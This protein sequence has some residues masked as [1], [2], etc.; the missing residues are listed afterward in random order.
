MTKTLF[1]VGATGYTGQGVVDA[2]VAAGHRVVAHVRP[3]SSAGEKLRG[4]WE[5]DGVVVVECP[6]ELEA[7]TAAMKRHAP[8]AVFS[9]LGTTRRRAAGEGMGAQEAYEKV[10]HDLSVMALE[11]AAELEPRPRFV[12]LSALGADPESTSAYVRARGKVEVRIRESTVPYTIARPS[13]ITGS[14][15]DESRPME[16]AGAVV[17]DGLLGIVGAFG[18]STVRDRYASMTGDELG[19]ALVAAAVDPAC[20]G[21]ILRA[22]DLRALI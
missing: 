13:F 9:L 17:A 19:R 18:G 21:K 2:G 5:K 16:R 15:R 6:F 4:P 8:D 11:A 20:A 3:G 12:F 7:L 10:D 14:D 1:V 22:D